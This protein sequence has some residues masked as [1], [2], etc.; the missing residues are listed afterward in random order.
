MANNL[1]INIADLND[2]IKRKVEYEKL[3]KFFKIRNYQY[4]GKHLDLNQSNSIL[5][6]HYKMNLKE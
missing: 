4:K 2:V 6:T 3:S 5:H 1:N